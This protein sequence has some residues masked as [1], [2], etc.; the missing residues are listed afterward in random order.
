MHG[1]IPDL[2]PFVFVTAFALCTI[3]VGM[4]VY[5]WARYRYLEEL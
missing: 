3:A 4:R 1:T 5:G 2:T